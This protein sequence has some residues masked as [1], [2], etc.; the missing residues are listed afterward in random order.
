[1]SET[2]GDWRILGDKIGSGYYRE[3][4]DLSN[5]PDSVVKFDRYYNCNYEIHSNENEQDVFS[6]Y[7]HRSFPLDYDGRKFNVRL[8][9]IIE[10]ASDCS[11]IVMEKVKNVGNEDILRSISDICSS[12][13]AGNGSNQ[14]LSNCFVCH[15]S[16][17]ILKKFGVCDIHVHNFGV[18]LDNMEIVV[19]DYG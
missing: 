2:V 19:V 3:V 16:D 6:V 15:L 8:A 1:M 13:D 7:G 4:F 18:D 12:C 9:S 14:G 10:T 5:D 11:W 17:F